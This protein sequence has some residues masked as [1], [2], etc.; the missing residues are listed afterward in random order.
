MARLID[1]LNKLP[2]VGPKSAQRLAYHL[3]RASAED[4]QKLRKKFDA[5]RK[6]A[7]EARDERR[8]VEKTRLQEVMGEYENEQAEQSRRTAAGRRPFAEVVQQD[9]AIAVYLTPGQLAKAIDPGN[10]LGACGPFIDRARGDD[11]RPMRRPGD[12]RGGALDVGVRGKRWCQKRIPTE[13]LN[14]RAT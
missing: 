14:S 8:D 6:M 9:R 11:R 13:K 4:A 10:Y 3:L 12:L 5:A 2:G 1:E 7:Q